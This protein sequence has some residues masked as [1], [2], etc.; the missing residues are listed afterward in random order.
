VVAGAL[1]TRFH[2]LNKVP[3]PKTVTKTQLNFFRSEFQSYEL[4]K[5]VNFVNLRKR[6]RAWRHRDARTLGILEVL[7]ARQRRMDEFCQKGC[8]EW[9]LHQNEVVVSYD[10]EE[11]YVD[12]YEEHVVSSHRRPDLRKPVRHMYSRRQCNSCFRLRLD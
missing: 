8:S 1:P 2:F 3:L 4:L 5:P 6:I 9:Q 7:A 12:L 11:S 10:D